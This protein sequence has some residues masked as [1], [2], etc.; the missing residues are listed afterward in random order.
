MRISVKR[1]FAVLLSLM[2]CIQYFGHEAVAVNAEESVTSVQTVTQPLDFVADDSTRGNLETDGYTWKNKTLTIKNLVMNVG[3]GADYAIRVPHSAYI[4]FQGNNSITYS[5]EGNAVVC[6]GWLNLTGYGDAVLD[7]NTHGEGSGLYT[8]GLYYDTPQYS[9]QVTDGHYP[10]LNI[11]ADSTGIKENLTETAAFNRIFNFKTKTRTVINADTGIDIPSSNSSEVYGTGSVDITSRNYGIITKTLDLGGGSLTVNTNQA[12]ADDAGIGLYCYHIVE[13]VNKGGSVD[14]YGSNY[15]FQSN[16]PR[17]ESYPDSVIALSTVDIYEPLRYKVGEFVTDRITGEKANHL[18]I[19]SPHRNVR[20]VTVIPETLLMNPGDTSQLSV[21]VDPEEEDVYWTTD[22][23]DVVTVDDSGI[24]TAVALGTATVKAV[25]YIGSVMGTCTVTVVDGPTSMAFNPVSQSVI[26]GETLQLTPEFT[27][28]GTALGKVVWSSSDENIASVD[29]NGL[30]T[31]NSYGSAVITASSEDGLLSASCNLSVLKA[32]SSIMI[33]YSAIT[34][35]KN[36]TFQIETYIDPVDAAD[37]T[38]LWSSDNPSVATVDASGKVTGVDYGTAKITGTT[39]DKGKTVTCDVTVMLNGGYQYI[40]NG[41]TVAISGYTGVNTRLNIPNEIDGK[42][43]TEIWDDAFKGRSDLIS[44]RIPDTV[45]HIWDR[46]FME[47]YNLENINLPDALSLLGE[48]VF[49]GCWALTDI[50]LPPNLITIGR[51][52]FMGCSSITVIDIPDSVTEIGSSAFGSCNN[53]TSVRLPSGIR[54]LS[55]NLFSNCTS[56]KTLVIPESVRKLGDS[57]FGYCTSLEK[58]VIPAAIT[59]VGQYM[60]DNC[61]KL[62]TAGPIGS[63]SNIE[64]GWTESIPAYGFSGANNLSKVT[65][66]EGI[67]AIEDSAFQNCSSLSKAELPD[68]LT[69]IGISAFYG[70]SRLLDIHLPEGLKKLGDGAFNQCLRLHHIN[71]P[72]SIEEYG[73]SIFSGCEML[74]TAGP[75]SE[76]NIEFSWTE[77]I[78]GRVFY[79]ADHLESITIPNTVTSI[80]DYAF[81]HCVSLEEIALPESLKELGS[82][83]FQ[84]CTALKAITIP[85]GVDTIKDCTFTNDINLKEIH[86]PYSVKTVSYRA[87]DA[88]GLE[89]VYYYGTEDEWKKVVVYDYNEPLLNANMH[90]I[91]GIRISLDQS[92]AVL[93]VG[94]ELQLN[95]TVTPE[96]FEISGIEWSSSDPSVAEVSDTGIV[97]ALAEGTVTITAVVVSEQGD[98]FADCVI[99]VVKP[100]E[101]IVLDQTEVT[102]AVN[103]GFQLKAEVGPEDAYNKNVIWSSQNESIAT[104]DENGYVYAYNPGDVLITAVTEDGGLE[105]Q[106][107]VTVIRHVTGIRLNTGWMTIRNGNNVTLNAFIEPY[108]ASNKEVVWTSSDESVATVDEYGTVTAVSRGTATITATS[109]DMGYTASCDVTVIQSVAGV[110]LDQ[111]EIKALIGQGIQM[112]AAVMPEDADRQEVMWTSS[113]YTVVNVNDNGYLTAVSQGTATITVTSAEGSYTD[114]CNVSVIQPVSGLKISSLAKTIAAGSSV[115]LTASIRPATADNHNVIWTSSDASVATVAK[116][117]TVTGVRNGTATITAESE[118]GGYTAACE[119]TVISTVQSISLNKDSLNMNVGQTA[120]LRASVT[121]ADAYDQSVIWDSSDLTVA[122]VDA[123]GNVTA[124]GR[125]T[126]IITATSVD[127]SH[128]STCAINVVQ[129]AA[130]VSLNRVNLIIATGSETQLTAQVRPATADNKAL[131]WETSDPL[132]VTVTENGKIHGVSAGTAVIKVTTA[133]GR[134]TAE[135]EVVVEDP[136]TGIALNKAE[137]KMNVGQS[138]QLT[139]SIAPSTAANQKVIW[140]SSDLTVAEVDQNGNVKAIGKGTAVIRATSDDGGYKAECTVTVQ[141]QVLSVSLNKETLSMYRGDSSRLTALVSPGNADN[142]NVTWTTSNSNIVTVDENGMINA[143]GA[144][145]AQITVRTNDGSYT[146]ICE[147]NVSKYT[148]ISI[149]GSSLGLDGK[150]GINFYLNIAQEDLNDLTVVMKMDEKED[151]R[152]PASEGKA[153]TVAGQ[154]LRMFVYP[155]AAKEM[156]DKVTLT[157]ED[158]EGNKI[159]LTKDETDYTEGYPFS[160]ADYFARAEEAGSEKTKKLA[161]VLNNYGK[162]AQIYFNYNTDEVTDLTD[163]SQ[164]TLET[165]APYQALQTENQV[166]GLTYVGGTTMLDDAVGY[167]LYFKID[168]THQI[169]DYTFKMDGKV[170]TPVKSGSQYYIEKTDIAAKDLGVKNTVEV[171][172]GENT[173]GIQYCALSYAYRALE[174]TAEDKIPLQNMC[175][176][177]YLYNQQAIEYFNN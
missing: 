96:E 51:A 74:K 37:Q 138:M 127:G 13:Q 82:Y 9:D 29:E 43:V 155:V 103:E 39:R 3:D 76:Y 117:G 57:V 75:G 129:P 87:F 88:S 101:S 160:A 100:A 4:D 79:W 143:V 80:T 36:E 41:D 147:L 165:L 1:I 19:R 6:E 23:S 85:D 47:C 30:V 144:G 169:S 25:S 64:F 78:P 31:G 173:F 68:S 40:D 58:I 59:Q 97:T 164:V 146:A 135:C 34:L 131:I 121:P 62:K 94:R 124:I 46:A 125:G 118:D 70:C 171:T 122:E 123:E 35:D 102:V 11:V 10:L 93:G 99:T 89:D 44:V 60:F 177:M 120:R 28:S 145:T 140:D 48:Y 107:K 148:G 77:S 115:K 63:G 90:Y 109:A 53:L 52:A 14:I 24:I 73:Q 84:E 81:F 27:P 20:S 12:D 72:I 65:I 32:V 126:A 113:D 98:A 21:T 83:V 152:V 54:E 91:P 61:E 142:R 15:A 105:A 156:R 150:I 49:S 161:R 174:L 67:K 17:A 26:E 16:D 69:S 55:S 92:E 136:V 8:G 18:V 157:V 128:T 116:D 168:T 176:A 45:V 104:V 66:P 7:I 154:K 111:H 130:G 114:S 137:A 141:Q 172:D 133:D 134:Y 119:I 175:R 50:S 166:A 108:D 153:S 2:L 151:I 42:P 159:K 95:A 86:I 110:T 149:Y 5:G 158:A 132:V 38:V 112:N 56:L 139:A 163:V 22:H 33:N 106:C 162:Y 167:R 170:V 71:L